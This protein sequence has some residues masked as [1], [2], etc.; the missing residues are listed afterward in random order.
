MRYTTL[1]F[2]Y[3]HTYLLWLVYLSLLVLDCQQLIK[4]LPQRQ[5]K[6]GRPTA[7]CKMLVIATIVAKIVVL[8]NSIFVFKMA[9][10]M[11]TE[12]HKMQHTLWSFTLSSGATWWHTINWTWVC[13]YNLLLHRV[14]PKTRDYIFYNNFNNKCPITI[15]FGIVSGKSMFPR[16]MVSFPTSPI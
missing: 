9:K 4:S 12:N 7:L 14:P 13:W 16:K 8:K 10:Y 3:L 6:T 11:H 15:I 1:W 5:C 2:T